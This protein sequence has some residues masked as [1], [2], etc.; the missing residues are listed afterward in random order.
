MRITQGTFSFLP[1]LTDEQIEAQI[2]YALAQRLVDLGRVHRRPAPAQRAVGDVG[3]AAFR[4]RRGRRR[5]SSCARCARA[6]RRIPDA[7][8]Q[9]GRLRPLARPPDDGALVHRQPAGG[10]ARLPARAPGGRR[11]RRSATRSTR[12]RPTRRAGCATAAERDST[13][14]STAQSTARRVGRADVE[15]LRGPASTTPTRVEEVLDQ[16]DRELIALAPGQDAHPRDRGAAPDR[17][18]APRGGARLG[19][20]VAAHVASPATRARAR[21]PSR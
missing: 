7:L 16:L 5:T 14:G 1:D 2:R 19:A 3:A 21:R 15:T 18:A 9:G 12:T 4:P 20:P 8:R 11:P 13:T 17:P 10:R 6:A